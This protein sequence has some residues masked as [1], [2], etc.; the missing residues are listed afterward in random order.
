MELL[1]GRPEFGDALACPRMRRTNDA[2]LLIHLLKRFEN[3]SQTLA[4]VDIGRTMKRDEGI[5]IRKVGLRTVDRCGKKLYQRIDHDVADS[6]DFLRRD[7][8]V[9]LVG[10][11]I[12]RGSEQEICES[13]CH[14]A[15]NL[16]RHRSIEGT[17]S[18]FYVSYLNKK[19]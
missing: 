13:V 9:T 8:L 11:A 19:F 12:L 1:D 17:K 4:V 15:I 3:A 7:A 14:D 16:L 5:A 18:R 10:V 6:V 2:E